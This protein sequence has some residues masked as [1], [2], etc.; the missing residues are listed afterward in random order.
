MKPSQIPLLLAGSLLST[1]L[2]ATYLT[3]ITDT[4]NNVKISAKTTNK[5]AVSSNTFLTDEAIDLQFTLTIDPQ[6]L[7]KKGKVFLVAKYNQ[8]YFMRTP[9]AWVP[10][11]KK[12]ESL[13][14][15][16]STT[17]NKQE[18][19]K[20]LTKEQLPAGEFLVYAAYQV[21]G[22][23][24]LNYNAAPATVVV[25]DKQAAALHRVTNKEVLTDYF[26][27]GG[28]LFASS[29]KGSVGDGFSPVATL[30]ASSNSESSKPAVSQTNLQEIGVDESD[31]V[32]V[33]GDTLFTLEKC[34]QDK[35]LECLSAYQI[36]AKPAAAKRLSQLGLALKNNQQGELY[37]PASDPK[38]GA[39]QLLY[40]TNSFNYPIFSFWF[41]PYYW[42]DN[43]TTLQWIDVSKPEAMQLK[44]KITLN[45]AL[46]SSRVVGDVLYLVTRKNPHYIYPT[47]VKPLA[48]GAVASK[49]L[50]AVAEDVVK[51][52]PPKSPT[53]PPK[54][55][56]DLLPTI[57][58]D[59]STANPLV[60]AADC[61]MPAQNSDKLV[62]NTLITITAIPLNNPNAYRSVCVAGNV[63][64]F[65]MSTQALYLA[66]SRY[67]HI[68]QGNTV[69]YD[70]KRW[71]MSTEIHKFA[72]DAKGLSYRGSGSVPGHLGWDAD[73]QPFRMGEYNDILKVATSLGDS[74]NDTSRTRVGVLR[75]NTAK[76]QL[77][78]IS[79]LDNLGKPGE[80]LYAARFIQNRGY[81]VTFKVIDPLYALDFSNPEKPKILG[82]LQINGYSDYLH[83]VGDNY[84]LGI[85][86]DAIPDPKGIGENQGAW[87]QGVKVSLFDVSD[88]KN[89][90]EVNSLIIG[91]RGTESAVLHDHHALA[92]LS[93][94]TQATLA[95]PVE[96]HNNQHPANIGYNYDYS[97]PWA[98]YDWTHT[99]LYTFT[100][101]TGSNPGI[102]L[103]KRLITDI[104]DASNYYNYEGQSTYQDRAVI[105]GNSVHYLHNNRIESTELEP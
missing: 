59:Q 94:G 64:T 34:A 10:W 16:K 37:L 27:R 2:A 105:Q 80:R 41:S 14:A 22:G 39:Q 31:R 67:P 85:G 7:G 71:E 23:E 21:D 13:T 60:A 38:T 32:K 84:L 102:K 44:Q 50:S 15:F 48:L 70:S 95:I 62:D 56:D 1:P 54:N 101:D 58:I 25:F 68:M 103:Q 96:L 3:P 81:L 97:Q 45:T 88:G 36:S 77:E 17:F 89:M 90:H 65:Y 20:V 46:L 87:Y 75:E 99:G 5:D 61:F 11:N 8:S 30:A 29:N 79:Y 100:V 6:D 57:S 66:T 35:S 18:V 55:V 53:L 40:I 4:S 63:D 26:D 82:E 19:I 76:Q 47:E 104:R 73:K 33:K 28:V 92:W 9:N 24:A 49:P 69:A 12:V 93:N 43:S 42:G 98:Y 78:E 72:L 74:W 83:P 91:K 51:L 86:K 52:A